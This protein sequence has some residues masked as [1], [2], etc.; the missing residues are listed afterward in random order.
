MKTE[1]IDIVALEK[2]LT[3][4]SSSSGAGS[5]GESDPVNPDPEHPLAH[6]LRTVLA[7]PGAHRIGD[8]ALVVDSILKEMTMLKAAHGIADETRN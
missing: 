1:A 8:L 3:R 5:P 7:N 6:S 4:Q 2:L